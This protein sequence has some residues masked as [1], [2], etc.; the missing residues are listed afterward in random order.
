[1]IIEQ[2]VEA[3]AVY[4]ALTDAPVAR[5]V[6]V[7]DLIMVDVDENNHPVGVEFA[8]VPQQA[9]WDQLGPLFNAYPELKETLGVALKI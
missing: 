7:S 5:T 9:T 3:G 1:M 4:F 8:M 6:H 2:D